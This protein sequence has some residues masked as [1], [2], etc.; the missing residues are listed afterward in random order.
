MGVYFFNLFHIDSLY[1]YIQIADIRLQKMKSMTFIIPTGFGQGNVGNV[2]LL[3]LLTVRR[4]TS[5]Q[6]TFQPRGHFSSA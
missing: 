5:M 1:I 6:R 2:P 4:C 3:H